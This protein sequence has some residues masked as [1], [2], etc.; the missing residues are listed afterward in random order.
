MM[1]YSIFL[2]VIDYGVRPTGVFING[3]FVEV[4][5]MIP[6]LVVPDLTGFQ[7]KP[8]VSYRAPDISQPPM[9]PEE[10]FGQV[11]TDKIARDFEEGRLGQDGELTGPRLEEQ[12]TVEHARQQ[13][14]AVSS[15]IV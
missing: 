3:R 2:C 7:L 4:P 14:L 15:D 11:Y 9:T 13:A 1:I 8:Y 12:T 10:L 6:E 5:E